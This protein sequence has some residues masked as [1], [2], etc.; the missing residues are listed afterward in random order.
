M[1]GKP[2]QRSS[3]LRYSKSFAQCI[4]QT[5]RPSFGSLSGVRRRGRSGLSPHQWASWVVVSVGTGLFVHLSQEDSWSVLALEDPVL[6]T[7]QNHTPSFL[8]SG[9]SEWQYPE[10]CGLPGSSFQAFCSNRSRWYLAPVDV[11]TLCSRTAESERLHV[12]SSHHIFLLFCQSAKL[13]SFL[14]Q[15]LCLVADGLALCG[16]RTPVGP[17]LSRFQNGVIESLRPVSC[18]FQP[19]QK[20]HCCVLCS[21][22]NWSLSLCSEIL[23]LLLLR[24]PFKA[25]P[26]LWQDPSY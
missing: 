22:L 13:S 15:G 16:T 6:G 18:V 4:L 26:I 5:R 17:D 14:W 8:A 20:D 3:K 11:D 10:S 19:S 21:F 7:E 2:L 1:V 12:A 23:L 24:V 25:R 9:Q